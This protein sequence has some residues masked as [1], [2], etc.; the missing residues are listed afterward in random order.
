ML[1]RRRFKRWLTLP[2]LVAI[3]FAQ[4]SFAFSACQTERGRLAQAIG[5]S[6]GWPCADSNVAVKAW[7][8]Y[9]NRCLAHCTADLQTA[10]DAVAL[11]KNP[12][13]DPV[14]SLAL[15]ECLSAARTGLDAPPPGA[16]P[17][18]ILLHSFLI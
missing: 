17:L 13:P 16:P 8:K 5:F 11:V 4:A 7:T 15:P 6:D 12:A 1:L 2:V 9:S 3:V 14:L 10:G 18:R